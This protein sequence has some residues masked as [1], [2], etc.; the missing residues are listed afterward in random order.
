M[1]CGLN[2]GRSCDGAVGSAAIA[3]GV[4]F[5]VWILKTPYMNHRQLFYHQSLNLDAAS[6]RESHPTITFAFLCLV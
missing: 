5:Y 1:D 3:P 4:F 6:Y 2:G